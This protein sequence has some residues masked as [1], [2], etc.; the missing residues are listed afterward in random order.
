MSG[1]SSSMLN[2]CA[3]ISAIDQDGRNFL[4]DVGVGDLWNFPAGLPHSIQGLEK[5]WVKGPDGVRAKGGQRLEFEYSTTTTFFYWLPDIQT[6]IQRDF[7]QIGIKLDIQN[8]PDDTFFGP[9]LTGGEA[10]PP[11]GAVAGRYD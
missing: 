7:R 8:Y 6:I 2:G 9:F 5:G 4:D 10:S 3:R 1:N 11:T